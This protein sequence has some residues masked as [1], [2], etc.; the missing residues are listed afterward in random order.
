MPIE[1]ESAKLVIIGGGNMAGAIV[2]GAIRAGV[3]APGEVVVC[4]PDEAKRA[5]FARAGVRATD[6]HAEALGALRADG[7]ALL[8]VKPQSLAAVGEQMRPCWPARGVVVMTVLAGTPTEKVLAALREDVRV[9][10]VM[11]N[12]AASIGRSVTAI[13]RGAGAQEGD[14]AFAARLFEGVGPL[15]V[16]IDESLM[17]AFTAVASSGLAYVFYL[18]EAMMKAAVELGFDAAMADKVVRG[19]IAGAAGMMSASSAAPGAM[20]AAVTSKGG[21]TAAAIG[22]LDERR[23]MEAIVDALRAARDRGRELAK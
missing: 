23:V 15:V 3:V 2:L 13:C 22:V 9:V 18:A 7:Q 16:R 17:D 5:D 4:E 12:I 8:A 11:P 20:R 10:R 6:S 14:D 19:T 1:R 21:T